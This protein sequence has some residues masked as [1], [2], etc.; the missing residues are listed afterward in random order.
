[1]QNTGNYFLFLIQLKKKSDDQ[2]KQTR[3]RLQALIRMLETCNRN[4]DFKTLK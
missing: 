4:E 3:Q 1:M 2:V